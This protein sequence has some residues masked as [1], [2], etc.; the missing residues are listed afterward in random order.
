M[1]GGDTK[2]PIDEESAYKTDT[3]NAIQQLLVYVIG[4]LPNPMSPRLEL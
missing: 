1:M 3:S 2:N 4:Q